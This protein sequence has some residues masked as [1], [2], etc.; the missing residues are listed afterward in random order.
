MDPREAER[1]EEGVEPEFRDDE[2]VPKEMETNLDL[3]AH[4][5]V[6]SHGGFGRS[7]LQECFDVLNQTRVDAPAPCHS[8][9]GTEQ[10]PNPPQV[11]SLKVGEEQ[12]HDTLPDDQL[13]PEDESQSRIKEDKKKKQ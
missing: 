4:G 13:L 1:F 3:G 11:M 5:P 12:V 9:V 10:L 2:E 8:G 7:S 6:V